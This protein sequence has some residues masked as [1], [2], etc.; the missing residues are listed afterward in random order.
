MTQISQMDVAEVFICVICAIC[1]FNF[2]ISIPSP[3]PLV[4]RR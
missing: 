2:K 3:R 4:P 1:G